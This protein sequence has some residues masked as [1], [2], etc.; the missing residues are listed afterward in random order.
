[1]NGKLFYIGTFIGIFAGITI[2]KIMF[3]TDSKL[4]HTNKNITSNRLK[5]LS[6]ENELLKEQIKF[7]L[8]DNH[9]LSSELAQR[10]FE[11]KK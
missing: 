6:E 1:M 10:E 7:L 4:P 8:Q 9:I 5:K 2:G 3:D 11:S